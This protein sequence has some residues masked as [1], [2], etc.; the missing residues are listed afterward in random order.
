MNISRLLFPFSKTIVDLFCR[1][2][3]VMALQKVFSEIIKMA[4]EEMC[5]GNC[6]PK[7]YIYNDTK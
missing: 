5:K 3:F 6:L 7:I 2:C 4:K 1:V